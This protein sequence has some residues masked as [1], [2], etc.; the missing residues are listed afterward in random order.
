MVYNYSSSS[1]K[2]T[3]C[4]IG[5]ANLSLCL[6]NQALQHEGV[7]GSERIE[8]R[9]FFELGTS[10]SW[11]VSFMLWPILDP[12]GTGTL[13]SSVVQPVASRYSDCANPAPQTNCSLVM[14]QN[15][16][17]ETEIRGEK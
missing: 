7:W 3:N 15:I 5:K 16:V 2:N 4:S 13:D 14:D 12:T 17:H 1:N 8:P 10:W 6:T 11:V 9:F